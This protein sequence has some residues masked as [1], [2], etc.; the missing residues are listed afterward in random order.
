MKTILSAVIKQLRADC[1]FLKTI[2]A[3]LG[4]LDV[5]YGETSRPPVA[6]PCVVVSMAVTGRVDVTPKL[7]EC[8]AVITVTYATD[9]VGLTGDKTLLP[10]DEASEV[11]AALQGFGTREFEPLSRKSGSADGSKPGLFR[12]RWTFATSY[13]DETAV[14][15]RSGEG[16]G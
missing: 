8:D 1:P 2:E 10:Y 4:Q 16:I 6:Y 11:Y 9:R 13:V 14:A 3:D 7:Q 12:Y 5:R 15:S